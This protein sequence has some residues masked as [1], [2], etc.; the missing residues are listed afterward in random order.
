METPSTTAP[1]VPAQ[2]SVAAAPSTRIALY[3][4]EHDAPCPRCGYNL[5]GCLTEEC[6]ECRWEIDVNRLKNPMTRTHIGTAV[7][8]VVGCAFGYGVL[9]ETSR[10]P[11]QL[12]YLDQAGSSFLM[13]VWWFVLLAP[14]LWWIATR[15]KVWESWKIS[16]GQP[17]T[18]LAGWVIAV[19]TSYLASSCAWVA[20]F[21]LFYLHDGPALS[22]ATDVTR[23]AIVQWVASLGI[24]GMCF[25]ALILAKDP[26]RLGIW[27]RRSIV[28]ICVLIVMGYVVSM[29]EGILA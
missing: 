9:L 18:R 20:Y 26:L 7:G 29:I 15:R 4:A 2:P 21:A 8:L 3:L 22:H 23:I 5:R 6:P 24:S 17:W 28:G 1:L 16:P 19:L 10:S 11:G 25:F 12:Q 27:V 13:L 14:S